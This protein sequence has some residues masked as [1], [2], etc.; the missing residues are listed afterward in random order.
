MQGKEFWIDFVRT[1]FMVTT[2]ITLVFFVVG[3]ILA[4]EQTF[5]YQAFSAPLVYA[6]VGTV[7]NLV[8]YSKRE[9]RVKELLCR[10]VLQL[11]L[12]EAGVSFVALYGTCEYWKQ[13]VMIATLLGSIFFVYVAAT[14]ISW[15]GN[16]LSAKALDREL[17][18][19][20][21]MNG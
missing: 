6:L 10:K 7:P 17:A 14:L 9:L 15:V 21:K 19:F 13:P 8:L 12:I 20:Q 4:P 2:L 11:L 1:F 5:G 16:L 18:E 3:Q